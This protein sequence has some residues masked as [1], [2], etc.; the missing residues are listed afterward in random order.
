MHP[1]H[2][3]PS[4]T[5]A[6]ADTPVVVLSGARQTGKSTI[7]QSLSNSEARSYL[8]LDDPAVMTAASTD[9]A[10]FIGRL[11]GSV[12]LD[13]IQRAP[14]LFLA[15]KASVDRDRSPG[16]FL[17]TSSANLM[18]LPRVVDSL[19]GRMQTISLWPLSCAEQKDIP[20]TNLADWLFSGE[21]VLM[22]FASDARSSLHQYLLAGGY[23]EAVSRDNPAQRAAWFSGYLQ[24]IMQRDVREL[25]TL[26]QL[27]QIQNL[28]QL[29]A[30]RSGS[31]LNFAEI[32]RASGLTQT[33]L[34]RYFALLEMLFLIYRLPAWE[35]DAH[36]NLV[37]APKIYLPDCGL[38]AY[39]TRQTEKGLS[40][41]VGLPGELVE[42][43]VFGE[44]LK[45][46][47][48]SQLRL[49]CR[50][51]R[52]QTNMKVDFILENPIGKITG[53]TVKASHSIDGKDF[54]GLRHLQETEPQAFQRGIVLYGGSEIMEFGPS[55]FAMPLSVWWSGSCL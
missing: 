39:L 17:L 11:Q 22:K 52:T 40:T 29:L 1:R 9:P 44:L 2:V 41:Q 16:R 46:L 45:H 4:L 28:L 24:T 30:V 18:L 27:N 7:A 34:K 13:E 49:K 35:R 5:E 3:L 33:T 15:I 8:T 54:K 53:I 50:H 32:S 12:V 38:L 6:L 48:F 47:S 10:G 31:L 51:Y 21:L 20:E 37:K 25:A 26:E 23:P 36:K 14:Q 43:F 42:T 55:L 19:A